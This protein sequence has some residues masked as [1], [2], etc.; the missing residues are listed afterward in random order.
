MSTNIGLADL[1][2]A[3]PK[4]SVS[5]WPI[6]DTSVGLS[7]PELLP[8]YVEPRLSLEPSLGAF[9]GVQLLIIS[10]PGAVGKTTLAKQVASQAQI[11]YW[12]LAATGPVGKST[13]HGSV[14]AALGPEAALKL[15]GQNMSSAFIIDALD[16]ARIKVTAAAFEAFLADAAAFAKTKSNLCVVLLGRTQIAETAWLS[17]SE[18]GVRTALATI[19]LFDENAASVYVERRV[20][21]HSAA[22]AAAMDAHRAPF[23]EARSQIFG[24]LNGAFGGDSSAASFLGYAPV[25]DAISVRLGENVNFHEVVRELK[26]VQLPDNLDS[27]LRPIA[28]LRQ[29]CDDILIREHK[30]KLLNN[31]KPILEPLVG[32]SDWSSWEALYTPAEQCDRLVCLTFGG[33]YLMSVSAPSEVLSR[34]EE[35]L[36][37]FIREHPFLRDGKAYANVVFESYLVARSLFAGAPEAK[38]VA[39]ARLLSG[40]M[41]ATRLFADF[42]FLFMREM[43]A[44]LMPLT[45]I[46]PVYASLVSAESPVTHVALELDGRDPEDEVPEDAGVE[47]ADGEFTICVHSDSSEVTHQAVV[48]FRTPV[49]TEDTL[50]LHSGL[51][52]AVVTLPCAV[53]IV[54]SAGEVV[55]GPAVAICCSRLEIAGSRLIVSASKRA[56]PLG[57]ENDPSVA[58]FA[59]AA[60]SQEVSSIS[61]RGQLNVSWP[62]DARHPW[63][64]YATRFERRLDNDP[65]LREC[66]FRFRR[67]VR[68][69]RSH[70]KGSLARYYKK[71]EHQR[72]LKGRIGEALLSRL[73]A[74]GILIREGNFYHWGPAAASRLVGVGWMD[75]R[76][77]A[78]SGQLAG[79]LRSFVDENPSLF[80]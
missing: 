76:N 57:D 37:S 36:G 50:L 20:R 67:I 28:L 77:G 62:E 21:R 3:L 32:G 15:F 31:M 41:P 18:A 14:M 38:R 7:Y 1:L 25:L 19:E 48:S 27:Q 35:Q 40:A 2:Q 68:T 64:P 72:V 58:L 24:L 16:E 78:A 23:A 43:A 60:P 56:A 52:E 42:Y 4:L 51:A 8:D 29:M 80:E 45:H 65:R 63:T 6:V 22:A 33:N 54:P 79:Y 5:S 30:Q 46:A 66:Y 61:V 49:R 34:Y 44:D 71:I 73:I 9:A 75:L 11:P 10:A 47:Y 53:S 59:L 74:D 17:A 69:L 39:E 26:T 12:D 55:V 13:F 70:S